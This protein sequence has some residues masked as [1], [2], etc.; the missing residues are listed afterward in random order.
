MSRALCAIR[1]SSSWLA[2]PTDVARSSHFIARTSATAAPNVQRFHRRFTDRW[3]LGHSPV[4]SFIVPKPSTQPSTHAPRYLKPSRLV[5]LPKP[6]NLPARQ[7][8]VYVTPLGVVSVPWPCRLPS[9]HCPSYVKPPGND[10]ATTSLRIETPL[11]PLPPRGRFTGVRVWIDEPSSPSLHDRPASSLSS[12]PP[13]PLTALPLS[14]ALMVRVMALSVHSLPACH[15]PDAMAPLAYSAVPSPCR[16]PLTHAAPYHAPP[17]A[18]TNVS[19]C[20]PSAPMLS[21]SVPTGF[22]G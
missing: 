10:V 14:M 22:G 15:G 21:T 3:P 8:P 20:A 16:T 18:N 9:V 11:S 19:A 2:M 4:G 5:I 13:L 12:L 1:I 7:P 17:T 6:W